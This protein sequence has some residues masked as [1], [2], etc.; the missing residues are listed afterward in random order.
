MGME[1]QTLKL[2]ITANIDHSSLIRHISQDVFESARFSK[3][4]VGRLRLVVDELY[5]N[6]CR[7]GSTKN[8]S[9][10][11]LTFE[12]DAEGTRFT[13]EDDGTGPQAK[14]A[15][16]LRAIIE[17]NRAN[18]DLT[19]TSGRGLALIAQMWTDGMTVEPSQYGGISVSFLKKHETSVTPP[20]TLPMT[21][22]VPTAQAIPVSVVPATPQP[23]KAAV[24]PTPPVVG[25]PPTPTP[26]GPVYQAKVAGE[27]DQSN[28]FEKI[29]SITQQVESMPPNSILELDFSELTYINSTFIGTLAGWYRT[30][31]GKGGTVRLVRPSAQVREILTLVGLIDVL[32]VTD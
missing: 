26:Q 11:V 3:E 2:A 18:N 30:L 25:V 31:L 7:Y 12:T 5:M 20:P 14:S 23:A 16:E 10:I 8:V 9:S 19:R 24:I 6:A 27:I 4:W 32:G 28:I 13:I 22:T 29:S 15:D 17:K 1:K 21:L